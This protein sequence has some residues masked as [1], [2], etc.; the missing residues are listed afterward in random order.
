MERISDNEVLN[1]FNLL[2]PYLKEF[3]DNEASFAVT[4]TEK[5]LSNVRND[6][7]D[8]TGTP[9]S[10]T[11]GVSRAIKESRPVIDY[12]PSAALKSY[13]VPVKGESGKVEGCIVI[14]KSLK[15]R[16]ELLELSRTLSTAIKEI[17]GVSNEFSSKLQ[18]VLAMNDETAQKID[19]AKRNVGGTDKIFNFINQ[20]ASQ[21][22]LL[23]INAA[24]EAA[25][26]D[27]VGKGFNVIA[28]EIRQLSE[29]SR[30]SVNKIYTMLNAI[31]KSVD[32]IHSTNEKTNEIT[33]SFS[34]AFA[35]ITDSLEELT[36]TA[37]LLET[38]SDRV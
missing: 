26:S 31:N 21:T 13:S 16:E 32:E 3:F 15:R 9:I 35:E 11:G 17:S 4:D 28:Q 1:A 19:E 2:I 5:F 38:M 37:H 34:T 18:S 30:E 33:A 25:R 29:T 27:T 14:G 36:S 12:F 10:P 8:Y 22:D 20:V 6:G 23:G 7:Q 24:I